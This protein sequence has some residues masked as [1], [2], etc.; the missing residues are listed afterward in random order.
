MSADRDS[1]YAE[2]PEQLA[3]PAG[4]TAPIPAIAGQIGII[5]KYVSGGS[6]S[7]VGASNSIGSTYAI[8]QIYTVGTSE[9]LNLN[10]SGTLYLLGSGSTCVAQ[11]LRLRSAGF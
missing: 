10:Q 7:I 11:I 1:V 9:I 3:L 2:Y 6:L 8:G 4:V 5:L